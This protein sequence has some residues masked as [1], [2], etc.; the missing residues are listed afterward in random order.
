M[1]LDSMRSL[2]VRNGV[3]GKICSRCGRWK[4]LT[5]Y[6]KK[7]RFVHSRCKQCLKELRAAAPKKDK[8]E[9]YRAYNAANREKRK[10][11]R[12]ANRERQREHVKNYLAR[13]PGKKR[14]LQ[15]AYY[16]RYPEKKREAYRRWRQNNP[17]KAL[18]NDHRRRARLRAAKGRF[19]LEEWLAL[20]RA[21]RH[22]CLCCGR[23]EP[24]IKLVP[25]HV[26]PLARG[27]PN[28]IDN[29]QPLCET[30]NKRKNART[31][32]Y[33]DDRDWRVELG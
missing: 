3:A 33:R 13:H 22:T 24:E 1:D 25:D 8:R 18:Q 2:D 9:D 23:H 6:N 26:I 28:D 32:D 17:E 12:E 11:Y 30:C 16:H 4:S 7:L 21:Y 29:I 5:E 20:K 15:R 19:T 14:E 31:I 10:A 27:G